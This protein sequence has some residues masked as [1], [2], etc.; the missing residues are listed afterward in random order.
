MPNDDQTTVSAHKLS[1]LLSATA[2]GRYKNIKFDKLFANFGSFTLCRYTLH[3]ELVSVLTLNGYKSPQLKDRHGS[4]T[5]LVRHKHIKLDTSFA[6][7][8]SFINGNT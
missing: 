2:L 8:G 7:F 3:I 5:V 4:F 1:S 6:N